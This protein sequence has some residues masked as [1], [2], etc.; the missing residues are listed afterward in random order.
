MRDRDA[1]L[2]VRIAL[3]LQ[4]LYFARS[5][6]LSSIANLYN[7]YYVG[8]WSGGCLYYGIVVLYW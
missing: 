7:G 4:I 2:E 3:G 1:D 5:Q 6:L 8:D